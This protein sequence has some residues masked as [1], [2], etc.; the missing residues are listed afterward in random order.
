MR[1]EELHEVFREVYVVDADEK[2]AD[3]AVPQQVAEYRNTAMADLVRR[4]CAEHRV[5]LVQLEYTQMAEYRNHTGGAPV[6]LVEHDLTFTLY[7]QL[8]DTMPDPARQK[9][10]ELWLDFERQALE[11]AN[12]VWTMSEHDRGIAIAH[13][14]SPGNTAVVP[15]GVDLERYQPFVRE[16]SERTILFVGSF[17][18]LPNLLAFE[19]LR[20]VIMPEVWCTCPDATLHVIAGPHHKRAAATTPAKEACSPPIRA[21]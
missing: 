8:A 15:N 18:H 12:A 14:A 17:R 10:Y 2:H 19:V 13:G 11:Y 21:S 9:Q 16:T 1:Y 6:I 5:D 3:A 4:L 7:R 20:N